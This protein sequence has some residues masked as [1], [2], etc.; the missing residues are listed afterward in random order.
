MFLALT[1]YDVLYVYMK[2]VHPDCSSS[3]L[4]S[5]V[6][7]L[8]FEEEVDLIR[9]CQPPYVVRVRNVAPALSRRIYENVGLGR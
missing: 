1:I 9:Q 7:I 4:P 2:V 5:L 3:L 6:I 8:V